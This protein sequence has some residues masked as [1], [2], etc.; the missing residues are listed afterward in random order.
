M[1]MA[2]FEDD[3]SWITESDDGEEN[4]I[5]KEDKIDDAMEDIQLSEGEEIVGLR[6]GHRRH[7]VTWID[8]ELSPRPKVPWHS[9]QKTRLEMKF[10]SNQD[11][12]LC[13][14]L[15]TGY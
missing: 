2:D 9:Q 5:S 14:C 15:L 8:G 12:H 10:V 11:A 7:G 4:P 1:D 6:G 13:G 3:R